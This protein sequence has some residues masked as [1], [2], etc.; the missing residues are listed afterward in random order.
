MWVWILCHFS[1]WR[2]RIIFRII[3][4]ISEHD[5]IAWFE[6]L[7]Y[8]NLFEVR[9]L[10]RSFPLAKYVEDIEFSNLTL[11]VFNP[12]FNNGAGTYKFLYGPTLKYRPML[13]PFTKT[14]PLCQELTSKNVSV[15]W[16]EITNVVWIRHGAWSAESTLLQLVKLNQ[17]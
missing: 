3:G 13:N 10:V 9:K 2:I 12:F 17:K 5:R 16:P 8:G 7:E 14:I 1:S 11:T 15:G 4:R 6:L